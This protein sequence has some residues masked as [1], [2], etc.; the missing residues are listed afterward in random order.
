MSAKNLLKGIK[1]RCKFIENFFVI[2]HNSILKPAK[3][4]WYV[5]ELILTQYKEVDFTHPNTNSPTTIQSV[6]TVRKNDAKHVLEKA[7]TRETM[8]IEVN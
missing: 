2:L 7:G 5:A 1:W 8:K 6:N 4:R 3:K